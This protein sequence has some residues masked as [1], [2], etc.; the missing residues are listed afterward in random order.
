MKRDANGQSARRVQQIPAK[1]NEKRGEGNCQILVEMG[2]KKIVQST[3]KF[4][5]KP[6]ILIR[7]RR[8]L[9]THL[10]R[11]LPGLRGI[12]LPFNRCLPSGILPTSYNILQGR[13]PFS[14]QIPCFTSS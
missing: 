1:K 2:T 9:V 3:A 7:E 12:R 11:M 8:T 14:L 6:K 5:R 13:M 4:W 10:I